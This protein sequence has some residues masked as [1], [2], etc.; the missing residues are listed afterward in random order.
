MKKHVSSLI[1]LVESTHPLS[2]PFQKKSVSFRLTQKLRR[3]CPES[4]WKH[5]WEKA[6]HL[7][8][9]KSMRK[10]KGRSI[11]P[12]QDFGQ[13]I[14]KEVVSLRL[15]QKLRRI[16]PDYHRV[17]VEHLWEKTSR[18]SLSMQKWK[19]RSIAPFPYFKQA[20]SKEVSQFGIDS[21]TQKKDKARQQK[22]T[23]GRWLAI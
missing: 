16:C 3:I 4:V 5:L 12:F 7:D 14:S 9:L 18:Y 1:I 2:K 10:W 20:I 17:S 13:T 15:T 8:M 6:R 21:E 11:A 23:K 22:S 19:V